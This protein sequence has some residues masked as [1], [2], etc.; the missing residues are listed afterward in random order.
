MTSNQRSLVNSWL[1]EHR[2]NEDIDNYSIDEEVEPPM[3]LAQWAQETADFLNIEEEDENADPNENYP[4]H[5]V[6]HG[7]KNRAAEQARDAQV[8]GIVA[9]LLGGG[10]RTNPPTPVRYCTAC[11]RPKAVCDANPCEEARAQR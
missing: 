10:P 2:A 6:E 9:Q 7:E 5:L 4:T 8:Q 3:D 11:N 1:D